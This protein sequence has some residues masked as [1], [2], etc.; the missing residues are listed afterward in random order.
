MIWTKTLLM[1]LG[2]KLEDF[3]LLRHVNCGRISAV[4]LTASGVICFSELRRICWHWC[5]RK[6][7]N[8]SEQERLLGG[9]LWTT[10]N[11][12]VLK[13]IPYVFLIL[14]SAHPIAY[15][16]NWKIFDG[17][18]QPLLKEELPSYKSMKYW[19]KY[20]MKKSHQSSR[21]LSVG[22][23]PP[24]N[25]SLLLLRQNKLDEKWTSKTEK[26]PK[27]LKN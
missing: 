22:R 26:P 9:Y 4:I 14:Q 21:V 7:T 12:D 15:S 3:G 6:R 23:T 13:S 10:K 27:Q 1:I 20:W 5:T 25:A 16:L 17:V 8:H 2:W 24:V 11:L 18:N 19:K